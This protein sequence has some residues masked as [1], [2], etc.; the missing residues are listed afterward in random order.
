MKRGAVGVGVGSVVV[1][2]LLALTGAA[3]AGSAGW[4]TEVRG[5]VQEVCAVVSVGEGDLTLRCTAGMQPPQ[6]PRLLPG[7]PAGVRSL[8]PLRLGSVLSESGGAQR[9]HYVALPPA[10]QPTGQPETGVR[11]FWFD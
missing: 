1:A 11:R 2:G 5:Q 4:Q 10:S 8:G 3:R 7:M 9:L 6:E